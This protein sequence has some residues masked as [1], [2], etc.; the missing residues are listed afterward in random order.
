MRL[1]T[2]LAA[3]LLLLLPVPPSVAAP[4]HRG[5]DGASFGE[6]VDVNLISVDAYVTDRSGH[7]VTGLRKEDFEI[8]E[9]GRRV[10]I[11]NFQ[12][13]EPPATRPPDAAPSSVSQRAGVPLPSGAA[14][15]APR[16]A[17]PAGTSAAAAAG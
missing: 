13:L 15:A 6:A 8:L 4:P 17:E 12:A 2:P 10:E 9:D 14:A 11:S 5:R 1:P 16:P 3:L 7:R